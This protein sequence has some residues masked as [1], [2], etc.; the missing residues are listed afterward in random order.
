[1]AEQRA[2]DATNSSWLAALG[3]VAPLWTNAWGYIV[4]VV[5]QLL[6]WP[7]LAMLWRFDNK[8]SPHAFVRSPASVL[9]QL[10]IIAGVL[11]CVVYFA[12]CQWGLAMFAE[13][14]PLLAIGSALFVWG[15]IALSLRTGRAECQP[16]SA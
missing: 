2:T 13:L 1:M 12:I 3:M 9:R 8:V 10:V 4:A 16:A 14:S 7:L 15:A 6:P 5:V 11:G